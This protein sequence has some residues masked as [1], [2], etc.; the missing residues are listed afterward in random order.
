MSKLSFKAF[1][2]EFYAEHTK[3][4]SDDVY[5]L[6]KETEILDILEED[7]D[8]FHGMGMEYLMNFF[9]EYLEEEEERI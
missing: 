6:F 4:P 2:I 9:D 1:C 5:R 7:Y 8:Q 3:Q